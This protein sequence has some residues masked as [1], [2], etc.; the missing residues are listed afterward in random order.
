MS[1]V[2]GL[3][4]AAEADS[5][6]RAAELDDTFRCAYVEH[7]Q[8]VWRGLRRLGVPDNLLEDA[9]QDVF[10][11]VHRRWQDFQG[12]SQLRTWVY[13]I[14]IKVARDYRRAEARH[15]R[16]VERLRELGQ[17]EPESAPPSDAAER[18]E[19]HRLL[20]RALAALKDEHRALIVLVELEELSVRDAAL[21]LQLHV[22]TCQRRLKQ[23][24]KAF[25]AA[26]AKELE[27]AR[28]TDP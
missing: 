16:R 5:A 19:A 28:R 3:K 2:L 9:V 27:A 18:N 26:M 1:A 12:R 23:A 15:S 25:E 22:R 17:A 14:T 6:A 10:L 13:G 8:L 24:R 21:A 4:L 20:Y 7:F 11:V